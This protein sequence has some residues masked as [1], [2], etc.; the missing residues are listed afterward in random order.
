VAKIPSLLLAVL[1]MVPL[2]RAEGQPVP[3]KPLPLAGAPTL[4][5]RDARVAL[6]EPSLAARAKRL[7]LNRTMF[8]NCLNG[9]GAVRVRQDTS[10]GNELGLTGTPTFFIGTIQ[11][12][13]TVRVSQRFEGA[14]SLDAFEAVLDRL[15]ASS[16]FIDKGQARTPDRTSTGT[17]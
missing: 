10:L 14:R 17:R 8:T 3:K 15:I 2:L 11:P 9:V 7:G 16:T 12:D 6:D 5:S 4:G 1:A 13:A